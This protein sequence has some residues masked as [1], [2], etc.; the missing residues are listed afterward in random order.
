MLTKK[1][2]H[3]ICWFK[4]ISEYEYMNFKHLKLLS[5][6]KCLKSFSNVCSLR[7]ENK[8]FIWIFNKDSFL[9]RVCTLST[10]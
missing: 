5:E 6:S 1:G 8:T 10:A 7:D 2:K 3:F 4:T 9:L